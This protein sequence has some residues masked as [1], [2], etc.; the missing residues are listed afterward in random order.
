MKTFLSVLVLLLTSVCN[1]FSQQYVGRTQENIYFIDDIT[2]KGSRVEFVGIMGH[3]HEENKKFILDQDNFLVTIFYGDCS[4]YSYSA[5]SA[6]GYANGIKY[7]PEIN[8][9]TLYAVKPQLIFTA[10][11]MACQKNDSNFY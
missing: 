1:S 10:L 3:Y 6:S 11:S 7:S 8:K 5:Q 4:D 2:Q 9:K